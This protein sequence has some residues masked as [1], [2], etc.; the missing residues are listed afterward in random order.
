[1]G[2]T[3]II[4][5]KPSVARD[6]AKVFSVNGKQD[7]YLFNDNTIISW[8]VGHLVTL[9]E[10]EDYDDKYK[11]WSKNTLPILPEKM[12]LK[13]IMKTKKQ[14]IILNNL[15]N[16]DD[17]TGIICATDS[18]REGELIFRYIYEITK[19][20]KPFQ[21]LW[22][23]SMTQSAIKDGFANLKDGSEYDNLYYSAKCRS[24]ADWLVGMNATRA[25]TL[26]YNVLLSLGR[27]QTPTLALIVEKQ[28]EI[29][30]FV[31]EE[32]FE[33]K[34]SFADF[35]AI[36]VNEK[37]QTRIEKKESA[38][39]IADKI[40]NEMATVA[41]VEKE[42]KRQIPQQLYDLTELQREGNKKFG[43]SAKQT[44]DI[45]QSLYEKQK[46]IT[47]PR[48]DSRYLSDDMIPKVKFVLGK[49][50]G[51]NSFKVY[52]DFLENNN[53]IQFTK[54]IV[55]KTKVTDHHAIIPTEKMP[56]FST[57]SKEELNIYTL[58]VSRFISIFHLNYTYEVTK[59]FFDCNGQ[60]L[61]AKGTVVTEEGWLGV[62]KSL[63]PVKAK[64]KKTDDQQLPM[65]K[66]GDS[67]LVQKSD[68]LNK[69]T[70]PPPNYTESTL[71][72]AM[73]N[74]GR[75]V[76]DESLKEQMKDSGLGTPATRAAT[77][78]RLLQVGYV[79]RKGKS[80]IPTEK[81]MSLIAVAPVELSSPQTTG[82]WEKGLSAIAKGEMTYDE[83]MGS[84]R[85][86]VNFLVNDANNRRVQVNFP[87]EENKKSKGYKKF[88]DF[89]DCPLC[90]NGKVYENT[91]SFYCSQWKDGCKLSLWK[92]TLENHGVTL[93]GE[94]VKGI[95]ANKGIGNVP[96]TLPQTKES[97]R[98]SIV[99]SLDKRERIEVKDFI[100]G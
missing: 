74:A 35:N 27:V 61:L 48:T 62:E 75:F 46:L 19:C 94:M 95:I 9:S 98:G 49:L 89:G 63:I 55:D 29:D 12:S 43:Y 13:G 77:I 17:V 20:K 86:Y 68:V 93:T 7:G 71:L 84:I 28:K 41:S 4:A 73:E 90:G 81:G 91:K 32:Y 30:A 23:S 51:V 85:R 88:D 22:I 79:I 5:E 26:Q 78:E 69:K 15:M 37:N 21:R 97:G 39:G 8:A 83:F 65:L 59:V 25:Y 99:L 3:L 18:G 6:I 72:S 16:S 54:R 67:H 36:S 58:V 60:K 70:T 80:I 1:M 57:L 24:E 100:K 64:A 45:A 92:N 76:E 34:A 10:P 50:K 47:Y 53:R 14:L 2:K 31:I 66:S 42:E 96:M 11:K 82:R 52:I 87:Q 40:K 33:V 44:L 38:K 56:N